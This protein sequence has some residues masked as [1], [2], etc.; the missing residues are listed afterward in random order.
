MSEGEIEGV[1]EGGPSLA[2]LHD[3]DLLVQEYAAPAGRRRLKRLGLPIDGVE[4]L[5]GMR[6]QLA[7]AIEPR[8]LMPYERAR[9]RYGRGMAA[10]RGHTCTGCYVRLPAT[11]RSRAAADLDPPLCPGCGRVLL[12]T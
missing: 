5:T 2:V 4:R 8:W 1:A 7:A 10:V 3:L 11:A 6:A 9:A 12:W